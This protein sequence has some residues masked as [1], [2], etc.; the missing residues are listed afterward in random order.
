MVVWRGTH[1]QL[2]CEILLTA[3]MEFCEAHADG[4]LRHCQ[5]ARILFSVVPSCAYFCTGLLVWIN[6]VE[7]MILCRR[8]SF[9][10]SWTRPLQPLP[11][12]DGLCV[13]S[14]F[15]FSSFCLP[16]LQCGYLA[17]SLEPVRAGF[18]FDPW[19]IDEE[20]H[21]LNLCVRCVEHVSQTLQV[22][23]VDLG[24]FP[25]CTFRRVLIGC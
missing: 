2:S 4:G 12:V 8:L 23:L 14:W 20:L 24:Y 18:R 21:A 16:G 13:V 5:Q 15:Y 1:P 17:Y 9:M 7:R 22:F 6:T 10:W 25:S 3:L 19:V 11:S